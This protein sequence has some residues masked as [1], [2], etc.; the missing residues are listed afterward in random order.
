M[1]LLT[2][3]NQVRAFVATADYGSLTAAAHYL[4]LSQPTLGR[5]VSSL[6]ESLG[7][8]LFERYGNKLILTDIGKSIYDLADKMR[9]PIKKIEIISRNS[10]SSMKGVVNITASQ[11]DALYRLPNIIKKIEQ[12]HPEIKINII[13]SNDNLN[14]IEREVDIA[15]R[16]TRPHELNLIAKKIGKVPVRL[17]GISDYV[18]SIKNKSIRDIKYIGFDIDD[19]ELLIRLGIIKDTEITITSNFK[20]SFQPLHVELAKCGLGLVFLPEDIGSNI[21][22]FKPMEEDL[23][24]NYDSDLWLVTHSEIRTSSRINFVFNCIANSLKSSFHE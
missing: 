2:D 20:S 13:V 11:I 4:G 21:A 14:L 10:S 1:S 19:E 16:S 9:D 3:W 18:D 7:V 5:Q 12:T 6:E 22:G 15:I 17:Y 8:V 23:F 24:F